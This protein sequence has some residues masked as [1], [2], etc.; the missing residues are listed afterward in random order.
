MKRLLWI[1]AA[2]SLAFYLAAP[3]ALAD[4]IDLS[5]MT[6]VG[7]SQIISGGTLRLTPTFDPKNP[8][9]S[10]PSGAAWTPST[11]NV[12]HPF[13]ANFQFEM[14]DPCLLA[15]PTCVNDHGRGGDG[16]AFL[17]QDASP[18]AIGVGAGGMGFLG[19][20]DSV[21]VM[22]DTYQNVSP[23]YYGDP[24]NNYIAINTRGTDFNVPH[25]YCT[26]VPADGKFELTADPTL[27]SDLKGSSFSPLCTANPTLAM[28]GGGAAFGSFPA[29]TTNIDQGLHDVGVTYTGSVLDVYLD[30]ALVLSAA[31]D[32][33]TLLDLQGGTNA[34]LGFTAGTRFAYQNQDIL[35]FS[36]APIPEPAGSQLW[37]A[38]AGLLA[39]ALARKWQQARRLAKG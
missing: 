35:S 25:H 33:G 3:L 1:T 24:S 37:M 26:F 38:L 21:A 16:I 20:S 32:L 4:T 27:P 29:L 14:S 39:I 36:E 2:L 19:I 11:V 22:L 8:P 18:T 23:D 7:T 13:S 28:T 12:V 31:M 5:T 6:L 9:T 10:I 30:S 17:I 34:Y 15:A